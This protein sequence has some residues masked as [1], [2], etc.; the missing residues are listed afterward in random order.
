MLESPTL[1]Y[2]A[3]T[4]SPAEAS[5]RPAESL[6]DRIVLDLTPYDLPGYRQQGA[7]ALKTARSVVAAAHE[8]QDGHQS[9]GHYLV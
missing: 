8:A 2:P 5:A 9:Q 1:P 4:A 6:D 3:P 7:S